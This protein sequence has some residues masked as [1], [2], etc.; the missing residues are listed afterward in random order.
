MELRA[1]TFGKNDLIVA[2]IYESDNFKNCDES[3]ANIVYDYLKRVAKELNYDDLIIIP[4]YDN[5]FNVL[6][7]KDVWTM[8][9]PVLEIN[10]FPFNTKHP[11]KKHYGDS[12]WQGAELLVFKEDCEEEYWLLVLNK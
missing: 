12:Q 9:I 4:D 11:D 6:L 8:S 5:G 3:W 7:P 10:R 1:F 2:T